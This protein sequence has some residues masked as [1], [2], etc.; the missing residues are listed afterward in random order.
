[1]K[2]RKFAWYSSWLAPTAPHAYLRQSLPV[3]PGNTGGTVAYSIHVR[4]EVGLYCSDRF[5]SSCLWRRITA[6]FIDRRSM[7]PGSRPLPRQYWRVLSRRAFSVADLPRPACS[8][9]EFLRHRA[10][11][12]L[13]WHVTSET[14]NH[15][16]WGRCC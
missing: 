11:I 9:V 4:H 13:L 5:L 14:A 7:S 15:C 3:A 2:L 12:N 8:A 16:R 1:M 10:V 6:I